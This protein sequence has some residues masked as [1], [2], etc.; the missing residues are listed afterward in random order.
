[1]SGA[2]FQYPPELF[3]LMVDAIAVLCKSKKEVILFFRGAGVLA[4]MTADIE[5]ALQTNRDSVKKHE[6]AR[7]ILTR[8][9][10]GGDALLLARRELLKRVTEFEDFS[11]CYEN[12]VMKAKGLVAEIRRVVEVKD[13]FTRKRQERDREAEAR[14]AEQQQKTAA[15]R[16]RR[17][18]IAVAKAGLFALFGETNPQRQGGRHSKVC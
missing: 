7:T 11:R 2:T 13:S 9:N 14:R 17:E 8:I 5:T 18:K 15:A 6:S 1:M 12:D 16:D 10:E 3:S 4:S